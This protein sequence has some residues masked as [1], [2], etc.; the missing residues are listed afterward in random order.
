M[1]GNRRLR[2]LGIGGMLSVLVSTAGA[3][4]EP[5]WVTTRPREPAYYIGIGMAERK[6]DKAAYREKARLAALRDLSSEITVTIDSTF[7]LR[8]TETTGLTEEEVRDE[9]RATVQAR[10]S[11][12]EFVDD[13]KT[14]TELWVYYRLSR[15]AYETQRT[16]ARTRAL[17]DA[18]AA[19]ADTSTPAAQIRAHL[20]ALACLLP[21]AGEPEPKQW[22]GGSVLKAVASS[23]GALAA[24]LESIELRPSRAQLFGLADTSVADP[25]VVTLSTRHDGQPLAGLPVRFTRSED[26]TDPEPLYSDD[27]G[28]V[29]CHVGAAGAASET[30]MI[31]AALDLARLS[32][33]QVPD[34][35]FATLIDRLPVPRVGVRLTVFSA[36]D[37]MSYLWH[38]ALGGRIVY[39][40]T[41]Y[42][43]DGE[44]REWF[45]MRDEMAAHVQRYGGRLGSMGMTA[46][47][48]AALPADASALDIGGDDVVMLAIAD[49]RLN[50]RKTST[51]E[52]V[53][54]SGTIRTTAVQDGRVVFT[55]TYQGASGFNPMGEAMCMDVLGLHAIERWKARYLAQ[56]GGGE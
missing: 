34:G 52:A 21:F 37:R 26:D 17:A 33:E 38:R 2:L 28:R 48:I 53:A 31:A 30:G 51:G 35:F 18:E 56:L 36:A 46:E 20:Q 43:A 5:D 23:H 44:A 19:L 47:A 14:R 45:K 49:G 22:K 6:G 39:I 1:G 15:R 54:F 40:L 50:R 16:R 7:L 4:G 10:L 12:V 9:T 11:E 55:D 13:H 42:R 8:V 41:A 29:I 32:P 24:L 27:G 25:L 3:W